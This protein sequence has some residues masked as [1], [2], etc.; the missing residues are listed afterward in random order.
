MRV[1]RITMLP[2]WYKP[3]HWLFPTAQAATAT[4]PATT[5]PMSSARER[6]RAIY[7]ARCYFCHG[8]SGDARTVAAT[9]LDP[10]PRDFTRRRLDR[11]RMIQAVSHGKAGTAMQAFKG[12][13]TPTEIAWV[14]DYVREALMVRREPNTRYHIA[15][16]GWPNHERYAA[17]FPFVH[18]E[19]PLSRPVEQLT[20]TQQQG[21]RL[22]M[23]TCLICHDRSRHEDPGAGW[24]AR[25]LSSPRNGYAPGDSNGLAAT[26]E[27]AADAV[28]SA[29]VYAPHVQPPQ[30]ADLTAQQRQGERLFQQNCAFCHAPDGT[31]K[32]WIGRFLEPHPRDLTNRAA[33]RHL[34][35]AK[36]KAVIHD[37]V[38][39][40]AMSAWGTVLNDEQISAIVS[41]VERVFLGK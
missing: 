20:A 9:Y 14:V 28:S 34:T 11:R 7:N 10:P 24:D 2:W 17:A 36:L 40:T 4:P 26:H 13:L 39:G 3:L 25:P 30:V 27:S 38:P 32:N 1:P 15:Q 21:R 41:Y 19:I 12:V 18:G 23:G 33:T 37:G 16:N 31:A 22:F 8:Y 29:S 5:R 6:G 35:S